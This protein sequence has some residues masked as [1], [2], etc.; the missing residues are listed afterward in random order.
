MA[1][2]LVRAKQA[3]KAQI[4]LTQAA[5]QRTEADFRS[6]AAVVAELCAA[7]G[8]PMKL[9]KTVPTF[10]ELGEA[11]TSGELH[12]LYP[13]QVP[14]K[15]TAV[16][17]ASRLDRYAYPIIGSKP[18]NEVTLDD[19]E[20]IM[21]RVPP[22][23]QR[24]RRHIAGTI[25]RVFRMAVYPCRYIEASPLPKGFLPRANSRKA[26]TYLYPANDR[27]AARMHGRPVRL[28]AAL[29]LPGARGNAG[30]G[31]AGPDLGCR[32]PRPRHGSA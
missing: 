28:P 5:E 2:A 8:N 1:R 13:D 6:V 7:A 18:I 4:V 11:W 20:E 26:L 3:A 31:G 12:K 23:A 27:A 15:D 9:A 32:R 14:L 25:A 10:R 22:S 29:G 17:D 21:R 30:R 24:S 16:D 19:C